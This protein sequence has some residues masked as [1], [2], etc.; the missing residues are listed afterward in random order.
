MVY[1]AIALV[2][3]AAL[4]VFVHFREH[5]GRALKSVVL[6][7]IVAL[8]AVASVSTTIQVYRIGDSG[9]RQLGQ[10][11]PPPPIAR[12][13]L[14]CTVERPPNERF[15]MEFRETRSETVLSAM[16]SC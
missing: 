9:A 3:A 8:V 13:L 15:V 10:Q 14:H 5:R 11:A 1:F 7:L 12:G 6:W 16:T 4:L 2:A